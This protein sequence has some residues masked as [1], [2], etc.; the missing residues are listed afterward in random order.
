MMI[1]RRVMHGFVV[2]VLLGAGVARGQ[3]AVV[4]EGLKSVDEDEARKMI[5]NQVEAVKEHGASG[6]RAD[7]AA[8]F[9]QMEL[10]KRGY[11]SA[12]V[13]WDVRNDKVVLLTVDEGKAMNLGAVKLTGN[14]ALEDV[15]I[16]EL[17]TKPTRERLFLS[18]GATVPYVATEIESGVGVVGG[19][20]GLLGY[21]EAEVELVGITEDD[22]VVYLEL[23]VVEGNVH[24]VGVITLP[25]L[26]E[27]VMIDGFDALKGELEGKPY[28]SAVPAVLKGHME[29]AVSEAGFVNVAVTVELGEHRMEGEVDLVDLTAMAEWGERYR[30]AGVEVTG[31]DEIKTEFFER[32]FR[33]QVGETYSPQAVSEV[34]NEMLETGAFEAV[35]LKP[36]PAEDG[37]GGMT[38]GL[39]VSEAKMR[40]VGVGFGLGTYEGVI[41]GLDYRDVEMFGMAR[42]FSAGLEYSSRGF[43]GEIEYED[44]WFLWSEWKLNAGLFSLTRE[45]EGYSKFETGAT[46]QFTREF[47]EEQ[48]LAV[49]LQPAFTTITESEI[50]SAFIGDEN[51]LN[52]YLGMSYVY[53]TRDKPQYPKSGMVFE[54]TLGVA[55]AYT[56]SQVDYFRSTVR[57]GYYHPLWK[58]TVR[59]NGRAGIVSPS[60]DAA[61]FPIDLR[62][63]NGGS[64]SVRSFGERELGPK[65]ATGRYP[66]GGEFSTVFNAEYDIPVFGELSVV[67]F[68]DAGNLVGDAGFADMHYAG[69]LGVRLGTPIGPLR[70]DYGHNLNR[71]EYEPSGT[72]QV[73]FGVA[74]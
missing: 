62:L 3:E 57:L 56:G 72:W 46:L 10:R 50:D 17:L 58:G 20:Y 26:P 19:F 16:V 69:G 47:G 15:A 63:F 73:G 12:Q 28:T 1:F 21:V 71:G 18:V 40:N 45:N 23:S 14:K 11:K 60:G 61:D 52:S 13:R 49:F 22:G 34:V 6:A 8:F 4:I 51:Y 5:A 38:L 65:D 67:P 37:S 48:K 25:E 41:V 43:L 31:N 36:V 2:L 32:M 70:I 54:T 74:F 68:F 53:D 55:A 27:G 59:L 33:D 7:D 30:L 66:V 44:P 9:L 42:T 39:D 24:R 35:M 64:R 29:K